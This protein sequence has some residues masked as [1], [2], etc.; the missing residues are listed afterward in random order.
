MQ[1]LFLMYSCLLSYCNAL[2]FNLL[3]GLL[4]NGNGTISIF[5]TWLNRMKIYWFS[6]E[7]M[8]HCILNNVCGNSKKKNFKDEYEY[9]NLVP[10]VFFLNEPR[11]CRKEQLLPWNKW[12]KMSLKYLCAMN[13][14]LKSAHWMQNVWLN[15]EVCLTIFD[16]C[17]HPWL[18]I[19]SS[20]ILIH[21]SFFTLYDR[22]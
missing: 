11:S 19:Q 2:C 4:Q 16:S 1:K 5:I 22:F 9:I 3:V 14:A 15:S 6:L 18:V 7:W 12:K 21:F 8:V 17:Q 10:Y 13:M 20:I